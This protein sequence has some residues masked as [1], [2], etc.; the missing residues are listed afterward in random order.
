MRVEGHCRSHRLVVRLLQRA[1]LQSHRHLVIDDDARL[2]HSSSSAAATTTR[3]RRSDALA[4]C[5]LQNR[6]LLDLVTELALELDDALCVR[7]V[8]KDAASAAP[9]PRDRSRQPAQRRARHHC[10]CCCGLTRQP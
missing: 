1:D 7:E 6:V 5:A 9:A 4:E 2:D 3:R 10:H 8:S